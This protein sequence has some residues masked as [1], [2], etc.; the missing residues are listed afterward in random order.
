MIR[1]SFR[2]SIPS[3]AA[4][5]L[6]LPTSAWAVQNSNSSSHAVSTVV[7]IPARAGAALSGLN[8][9][10]KQ[11]R[12]YGAFIWMEV[13]AADLTTLK[14]SG[15]TYE[16]RPDPYTL[17][18]GEMSFDPLR[19][20]PANPAGWDTIRMDVSDMH[21]VQFKA[22]T[23][24]A[25]LHQL[26]NR[27]VDII[28]YIH[29]HTYIV[30]G[31][32][33][34]VSKLT[35]IEAVRWTGPS[36]PAY[37]VLPQWR[38]LPAAPIRTRMLVYRGTDP[39][40]ILDALDALGAVN[41]E[42]RNLNAVFTSIRLTLSGDQYQSAARI[43]G[44][45]SVKP[46]PTDGG[47]RGEMSDQV[48]VNNVDGS[49]L[50][51]PGYMA[52]LASVGL[53]GTGVIIANVDGG[54]QDNHPDLISRLIPCSGTTCGGSAT[55]GHGTHTAGIMAA[56]GSSGTLDG[57]GF[58]RGLGVAPGANLV[59][60]KYNPYFTQPDG[61]L[62]IMADSFNN[63]ASLS[64]N[65]WGPAGTPQGYDDDTM[66][67]DIGVRD[68]DQN[69][70]GNQPLTY[71][72]SFMNGNGG[73]SSQGTPDEA[74]NLFNIGST[75]MQTGSGSQILEIDDVSGNSAHGPALDGRTIPHM[76]APGCNVDS[77]TSGSSYALLCGTSM[78]SPH[79]SGAVALFI[80]YFRGLPGFVADPSPALIKAAFLPV[81]H[82]LAGHLDADGI[83]LG[84]PFDSKQGWGRMNLEAVV[85]PQVNVLYFDD[86]LVL[87][88]TGEQW[89]T[90]IFALDDT[91]PM[92]V[93]LVWT[94]APGHGM[95]GS[96]PAWNNN[97][98][99]EVVS[100][101][102]TY[103]GNDFGVDGWSIP[104]GVSDTMNNTE[105]VFIGPTASGAYTLRVI[106]A[107]INSDGIPSIGSITDQDFAIACYN[108][109]EQPDFTIA[110]TPSQLDVCSPADAVISI[111]I[112]QVLGFVDPVTLS[113]S[114]E[115]AG[116]TVSFDVNPITPPGTSILTL[117][118]TAGAAPGTYTLNVTGTST[119]GGKI[120]PVTMN[121]SDII[122]PAPTLSSPPDGAVETALAPS[123][124]WTPTTQVVNYVIDIALDNNFTQIID[125]ATLADTNY[126]INH[127]L[128]SNTQHFWR[129]HA[130]NGCGA[131]SFS[132]TFSFTTVDQ[133][134]YFTEAFT[135]DNDL[136][137]LSFTY[138][139][140][141]TANHYA[142]CMETIT[143]LP[144]DPAGGTPLSLTDDSS[145]VVSIFGQSILF[146]GTNYLSFHVGSNGY[147][148]FLA[149]DT[150]R[151]ETLVDHFAVPRI[152]LLFDDLNPGAGGTI[153]Y[154]QFSGGIAVTY[155]NVPEFS[156][157]N[158]NTFQVELFFNG[159]IRISY[160]GIAAT[161]GLAGLSEG[162]GVPI[163]YI[164]TNLAATSAC[165]SLPVCT[166][167]PGDMSGADGVNGVDI[168]GFIGCYL[169]GDPFAP[170]CGCAD[171]NASA[172]FESADI[173]AFVD[174]LLGANCP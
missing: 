120:T 158:S 150:D 6:I 19:S 53:D 31:L 4:F 37:R 163:D 95:G 76:V 82:D 44:V 132:P 61:M 59:E 121:L 126:T 24:A 115:P 52:W 107:D 85:D 80:E 86:P 42:T 34:D 60:Q 64:G 54:V 23:R 138:T 51:F 36:V 135:G 173:T 171:M 63:G 66:Q 124:S 166:T 104:G 165:V 18:L 88:N 118:G 70:A 5:C 154:K 96:T 48:N 117:S 22:P 28:Q 137:F 65:S 33:A 20:L 110:A 9:Q 105:G 160:L 71:V 129:V 26:R 84:H 156:T 157:T 67:V 162:N 136:D 78:A 169:G 112:G 25:W 83:T 141:G 148:T 10:P 134:N 35:E 147:L 139:P 49:N 133:V 127:D 57:F 45:Y 13:D 41:I 140:N 15:I 106:A 69:A 168:D 38:N 114:G 131:G 3:L 130:D 72:L 153:S 108:C 113:A 167:V 46:V 47:L 164:E 68:A 16:E 97:L 21:L 56:D 100:G 145:A 109:V 17:R 142:A 14:S 152:S 73:T 101:T 151:T 172:T 123:F 50:A 159:D 27:N 8:L 2:S 146:Y 7:R 43:P 102:D 62:L 92:R 29:P 128:A 119:T 74:K 111:D 161:D 103:K 39:T 122:P 91:Q 87:N 1:R 149:G 99:L 93:M 77:S 79:V 58:L 75:K 30:W 90:T 40:P 170:G 94:D 32:D 125:T 55:S 116:T 12:D 144:T 174:C 143:A 89:E 11:S 155:E 81:A 98:D